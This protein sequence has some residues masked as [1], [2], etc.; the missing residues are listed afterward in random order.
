MNC[1]LSLKAPHCAKFTI[2]MFS[3]NNVSLA[4]RCTPQK[5]KETRKVHP[6]HCSTFQKVCVKHT[7]LEICPL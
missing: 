7:V 3:N 5:Q 2:P 1:Q 4:C 6:L